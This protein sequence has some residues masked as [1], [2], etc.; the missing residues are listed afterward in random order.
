MQRR[1]I[2]FLTLGTAVFLILLAGLPGCPLLR[3]NALEEIA[4][5]S[6]NSGF[7]NMA[8]GEER[9]V[10]LEEGNLSEDTASGD[11]ERINVLETFLQDYGTF[12]GAP[13]DKASQPMFLAAAPEQQAF[14]NGNEP[15]QTVFLHQEHMG[16]IVLDGE[17]WGEFVGSSEDGGKLRRVQ[18]RLFNPEALLDPVPSNGDTLGLATRQFR[19]FLALNELTEGNMSVLP[20]PVILGEENFTGFLSHFTFSHEDGSM[21]RMSVIVNPISEEIHVLYSMPA[22]RAHNAIGDES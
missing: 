10:S 6:G 4:L 9:L 16:A 2:L 19:L 22:C 17:V 3:P 14:V 11:Q 21:D 13:A 18:G 1:N 8:I 15:H 5:R 20:T 7:R 12:F